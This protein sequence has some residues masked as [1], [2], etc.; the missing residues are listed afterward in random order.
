MSESPES[1]AARPKNNTPIV[2]GVIVILVAA[3]IWYATSDGKRSKIIEAEGRVTFV[4]YEARQAEIELPDPK[5]PQPMTIEGEV[6]A[7][8]K[9]T[10]NGK[11]ATLE[12]VRVGDKVRVKA[13]LS[14]WKTPEGEKRK[15]I[16]PL[17]VDILRS[18]NP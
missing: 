17:E 14:K 16:V 10:M 2:V 1:S 12:D 4:D 6:P 7:D 9:F 8:C 5:R 11:P 3:G 13:S 15:K 18:E